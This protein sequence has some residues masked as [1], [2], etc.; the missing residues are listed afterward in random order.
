MLKIIVIIIIILFYISLFVELFFYSISSVVST[1]QLLNP[2]PSSTNY[3]SEHIKKYFN[4]SLPK[5]I[6]V[7]VVP[8][9][10]IYILHALPA[11]VLYQTHFNDTVLTNTYFSFYI[12]IFLVIIG[13]LIS[14]FYLISIRK[15]KEKSF[16]GFIESGLFKYSRNPGLIGLFISFLGLLIIQPSIFF[17][18]CFII[19]IVHMHFKIK[20]EEDYLINKHGEEYKLYLQKTRRYL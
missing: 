10:F 15:I 20:M 4:W 1:K 7:F 6:L 13:R 19:Y 2:K 5:K 9:V 17:L 3:F 11:Y 18:I 12:G 14:H 8:L 16:E